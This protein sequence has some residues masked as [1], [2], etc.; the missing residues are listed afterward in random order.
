MSCTAF[1]NKFCGLLLI[2]LTVAN[3]SLSPAEHL[4][5]SQAS[6][7]ALVWAFCI[8]QETLTPGQ[9][10]QLS[11]ADHKSH[12]GN[13]IGVAIACA[14]LLHA[15]SSNL[16]APGLTFVFLPGAFCLTNYLR[17]AWQ[18][19]QECLA[20][21][22]TGHDAG[23]NLGYSAVATACAFSL[24]YVTER[25]ALRAVSTSIAGAMCW[26]FALQSLE[27]LFAN[28]PFEYL[29][30]QPLTEK[31]DGQCTL[32]YRG[33]DH[34]K[35]SVSS[36]IKTV[37]GIIALLVMMMSLCFETPAQLLLATSSDQLRIFVSIMVGG[38]K[39]GLLFLTVSP[40]TR[41]HGSSLL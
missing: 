4:L 23:Q 11:N 40:Y 41:G 2:V 39:L 10:R 7:S 29:Q 16:G 20:D 38:M 22:S 18:K 12:D 15:V 13:K 30:I 6:S 8:A 21:E 1:R 37:S 19:R 27:K 25:L 17:R 32:N 34:S 24:L 35:G 36:Y 5:F 14:V 31:Q 33:Q 9:H 26:V 3:S 28:P